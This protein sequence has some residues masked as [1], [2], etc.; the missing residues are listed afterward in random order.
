MRGE[1][2][3]AIRE[4]YTSFLGEGGVGRVYR[5][6]LVSVEVSNTFLCSEAKHRVYSVSGLSASD[7]VD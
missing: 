7:S 2:R 6:G 1:P 3:A 4:L 5:N